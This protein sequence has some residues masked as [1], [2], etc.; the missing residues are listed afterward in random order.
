MVNI[1]P[2]D[3]TRLE[4]TAVRLDGQ[5]V[6]VGADYVM[7]TRDGFFIGPATANGLETCPEVHAAA[8]RLVVAIETALADK[9]GDM[10]A[11]TPNVPKGLFD[12]GD[13]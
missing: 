2:T 1:T 3:V 13:I 4:V 11:C 6:N 12:I 8:A 7:L 9:L 10:G 5:V